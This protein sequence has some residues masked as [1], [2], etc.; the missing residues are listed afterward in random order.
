MAIGH[1][2]VVKSIL[3]QLVL[4]MTELQK[5]GRE[6]C[7]H[8]R[9]ECN[10]RRVLDLFYI[11]FPT[12]RNVGARSVFDRDGLCDCFSSGKCS[13]PWDGEKMRGTQCNNEWW[14]KFQCL[15]SHFF[16]LEHS[17]ATCNLL[18]HLRQQP[19]FY[20]LSFFFQWFTAE[21]FALG[22]TMV[23]KQM[24]F[25][26]LLPA[27]LFSLDLLSHFAG[28]W[29]DMLILLT[30]GGKLILISFCRP[31]VSTCFAS[32]F[33]LLSWFDNAL[34]S[35][36]L[37]PLSVT[38]RQSLKDWNTLDGSFLSSSPTCFV[39][40]MASNWLAPSV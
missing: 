4:K 7:I 36:H 27:T 18:R 20:S 6:K 14:R 21:Q 26:V 17:L 32:V 29:T 34:P 31:G 5:R 28:C 11:V 30:S 8:S 12:Q 13:E 10:F 24:S 39:C 35:S 3:I 33:G 9:L 19:Q 15:T 40:P 23:F 22:E 37:W 1:H 16:L 38:T 25:F 2:D